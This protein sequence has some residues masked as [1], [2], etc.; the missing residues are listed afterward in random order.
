[1]V[2]AVVLAATGAVVGAALV[3]GAAAPAVVGDPGP[4]TR[5]GVLLAR[6]AHDLAATGTLG[7]LAVAVLV[8]PSSGGALLPEAARLVRLSSRWASAWCAASALGL[9]TALSQA[10][11]R[12]LQDV[13]T[14]DA[15]AIGLQLPH[16]RALVSSLWLAGLV[17]VWAR[18]TTTPAG[19]WLVLLTAVSA[20]LPP[21]V[22]GHAAHQEEHTRAVVGLA[23]H[24]GSAALW[25]GGL[26]A[27]ALHLRRSPLVLA[28]A[29]PRY[30]RLALACFL[31][32]GL[33]GAVTGWTALAQTSQLWT[34]AYG[35]LLLAKV[36]GFGL[37][38]LLGHL[39]RRRTVRAAAD[40]RP[41]AFLALAAAE[42]VLMAGAVGL[43]V[44]LSHTP[45]PSAAEHGAVA[46]AADVAA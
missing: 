42:V 22:T 20:L 7:V 4:L 41:R 18:W 43:A 17:A 27:L 25:A 39:H 38:G 8:L 16:T 34:T 45:P 33:S 23:V 44:G 19:G 36:A 26:I 21:L 5:W 15:L 30:S 9:V 11:G 24:V 32:V 35:Q 13:L 12:P 40:G 37:L 29:L 31:A 6:T 10:T 46:L 2:A 1:V 14:T 3:G 28:V